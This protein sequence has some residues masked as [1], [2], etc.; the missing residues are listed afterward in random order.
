MTESKHPISFVISVCLFYGGLI[1]I[2]FELVKTGGLAPLAIVPFAVLVLFDLVNKME[3]NPMHK[4][5]NFIAL[6][7]TIST[8]ESPLEPIHGGRARMLITTKKDYAPKEKWFRVGGSTALMAHL[9]GKVQFAIED[10]EWKF[11]PIVGQN[12]GASE[13]AYL[14]LGS[15]S[16]KPINDI[17]ETLM[18]RLD[19]SHSL[20]RIQEST[21][22]RAK[23]LSES[24]ARENN[25]DM[26]EVQKQFGVIMRE[27]G[28]SL[29]QF[30]T[31]KSRRNDNDR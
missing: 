20:V 30:G 23:Q 13:G 19:E 7:G 28:Q 8:V 14:Y 9:S 17:N 4:N 25:L 15:L 2:I 6:D 26:V 22:E 5:P 3:F 11:V 1:I 31:E 24:M 29:Q 27:W 21:Y 12:L 16:G 18:R 10:D